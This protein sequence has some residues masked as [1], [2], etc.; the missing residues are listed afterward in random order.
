MTSQEQMKVSNLDES[1]RRFLGSTCLALDDEDYAEFLTHCDEKF[2]YQVTT[3]SDEL[4]KDM[5]WLELDRPGFEALI[6]ML[7]QH[8]RMTGRFNRQASP[9]K[10]VLDNGNVEVVSH[11]A[12]FHTNLDG[13]T[14]LLLV[15]RYID[16]LK[17]RDGELP[18]LTRRVVRLDTRNLGEGMHAPI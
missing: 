8:V 2:T 18:V 4:G 1:V 15:G 7:P 13:D 10:V 3:F 9:S 17:P 14:R 11:L 5:V 12:M 6:K 16:Q